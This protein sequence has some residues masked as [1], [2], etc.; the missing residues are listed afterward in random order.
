MKFSYEE[1][2]E[3]YREW[4]NKG[5][6]PRQIAREYGVAYSPIE[7]MV[8]LIDLHGEEIIRHGKNTYYSPEFKE[9]AIKRVL[10]AGESA[11][12]VSLEL[13]LQNHGLLTNWIKMPEWFAGN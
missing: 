3:M 2:L 10:I 5:K 13:G 7:Y 12:S 8:R 6:S 4:K 11:T 9:A 1:K